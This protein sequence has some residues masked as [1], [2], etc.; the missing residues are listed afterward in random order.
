M[1]DWPRR[2]STPTT[3]QGRFLTL[4]IF[5]TGSSSPKSW[6]VTVRP[7][8]QMLDDL[9][10]SS[11][12]NAVPVAIFHFLISR[13]SGV[14]PRT[15][16]LQFRLPYTTWVLALTFGDTCLMSEICCLMAAASARVI[17]LVPPLPLRTPPTHRV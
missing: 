16:V 1:P 4:M 15:C 7:S 3:L 10:T 8:T 17:V 13:N 9:S 2:A 14:V 11:C 12:V 6:S 5:P